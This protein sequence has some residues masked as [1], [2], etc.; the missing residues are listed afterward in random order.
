MCV[1][2]CVLIELTMVCVPAI[3]YI[4]KYE[5]AGIHMIDD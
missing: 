2:V 1:C 4:N 3:Y 5:F